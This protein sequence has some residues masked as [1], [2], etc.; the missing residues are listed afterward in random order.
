M[1]EDNKTRVI[2]FMKRLSTYFMLCFLC[3]TV[4]A[5]AQDEELHLI[6]SLNTVN[7]IEIDEKVIVHNNNEIAYLFASINIDS[8]FF[9]I[10]KALQIAER[11][12]YKKGMAECHIYFAR[13]YIDMGKHTEAIKS[14]NKSLEINE[15]LKD[16]INILQIYRGLGFVY[17]H[18]ASQ[19]PCLN[20]NIKALT[21]AEQLKDSLSLSIIYNNIATIYKKIDNYE[22][23]I[24]YF[25]KSLSISSKKNMSPD[26]AIAHSNMGTV[27]VEHG[28]FKEAAEDYRILKELTPNI[29]S[30]YLKAYFYIS[31][32]GYY[33]GLEKYDSAHYY[34]SFASSICSKSNY[35]PIQA[36]LFRRKGEIHFKQKHYKASISAF[37][38]CIKLSNSIG[39]AQ[40]FPAMY[41]KKAHANAELGN[42]REALLCAQQA[43]AYTDSLQNKKIAG[44]LANFE[45][46]QKA[47]L[48]LAHIKLEEELLAQ[49]NEN[50][51]IRLQFKFRFVLV[52][53]ILL[54]I[55]AIIATY[56]FFKLRK[57][58]TT[59][60]TQNKVIREQ[61]RLIEESFEKLQLSEN[62]LSKINEA[63][64]K[65]F[66]IIA[67]DMRSPF[68]AILGFSNELIDNYDDYDTTQR[69]EMITMISN[70]SESTLFLLE[71]LLNWA[72]SQSESIA[73]K[74][75]TQL[76]QWLVDEST[77][78]YLGSAELKNL[79]ISNS[80][81][82]N[83][84]ICGDKET[85]KVVIS[86]LF[87]NAIK[88]S[89]PNGE[90]SISSKQTAN[91]AEICI[92]DS[93]IGM[94]EKIIGGLFKIAKNT[95]RTGT[96]NEKGTGL[97][98]I[99][100]KEFIEMNNGKIW[101][102]SE[103]GKGTKFYFSLPLAKN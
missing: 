12:D 2:I 93:G 97:G 59:L 7:T 94:N 71:N 31:I 46:D 62:S 91:S 90:I 40:E 52:I 4:T 24:F 76:L 82:E 50:T 84:K 56:F 33:N 26:I 102:E 101:V 47:K 19:I 22:S 103:V 36:R 65:L 83:V 38:Q 77:S 27:K 35:P 60:Q 61:K 10:K 55:I 8:T 79:I 72:R 99:L 75:E 88:F 57:T 28:N 89:Y 74:K 48:E 42:F 100:C 80:I 3:I 66:S 73:I 98:L 14:Y 30:D 34:T 45:K 37:D 5:V 49:Q 21:Y 96:A 69:K 53:S 86:N 51:N 78:P 13:A 43:L 64:D 25:E 16:S 58:N 11:I 17:S 32:A 95:Q 70:S 63:K 44:S 87:N 1:E 67:H 6:D 9:Y 18:E 20:Y 81:L 54:L 23:A 92:C 68:N 15:E 85:I 41:K 29:K 39:I